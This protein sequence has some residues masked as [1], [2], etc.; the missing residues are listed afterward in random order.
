MKK[1]ILLLVGIIGSIAFQ[2]YSGFEEQVVKNF[3]SFVQRPHEKVY[4]HTDKSAY[5]VGE[6]VWFR[7]YGV[8]ALVHVPEI[9]SRF[10]YVDLVDKRDSL[11]ERVKVGMRDSCFYGQ[12]PLPENLPQGEYCLRAYTYNLQNQGDEYLFKKKI[13]V[14]NPMDSKV[15]TDVSYRKTKDG[16]VAMIKF[17]DGNAEPYAR[18]PVLYSIGAR[19]LGD[20]GKK[21]YTNEKGELEIKIDSANQVVNLSFVDGK[22]FSFNR[23]I[24]VPELQDDFDVQFFPE[25]GS[26]LVGN[27]QQV[28]FKAIGS[29]GHPVKVVGTVYQDSI[30]L[31]EMSSEH[32][33]MGSFKL[34]V[35]WGKKF[36]ALVKTT[37]GMEKW[38]DLPNSRVDGWGIS[39]AK[40]GESMIDYLVMQ[41][42][43]TTPSEPLYVLV[44]SR[45]IV[46]D[47]RP[48]TGKTKG[49]IDKKLLPEGIVQVVLMDGEGKVYSQ[50]L[51]FVKHDDIYPELS[52][53]ADKRQYVAREP[54]EL[55][56]GFEGG[57]QEGVFSLSVTDDQKVYADSLADNILSNLLL[58]SDLRGYIEDP[59]YYFNESTAEVDRHLDLVMQ[60]HGWTRF[61]PGKITRGEFPSAKYEIEVAQMVSGQVKNFWG[62]RSAGANIILLSN[63][64]K[65]YMVETDENGYFTVDNLLF[66]DST[67][68]MVQAMSAKGNQRVEVAI[69]EDHLISPAYNLPNT[70]VEKK[71]DEEFLGK[72]GL[73][74]YYENGEKIYVLDEVNVTRRKKNKVYSFYDNLAERQLDSAKLAMYA[75]R[76]DIFQV[77][78]AEVPGL[79]FTKDT[80]GDVAMMDGRP[81]RVMVNDV[82]ENM[83]LVKSIPVKMLLN[84]SVIER[85]RARV[86]LGDPGAGGILSITAK[87]GYWKSDSRDRL[88]LVSFKLLGY[89]E[90]Q[91]FYV[92][93]Y[94]VDSVR[95]D[96]RYDER[97]TIYWKPRGEGATRKESQGVILH[98]RYLRYL[99]C[100]SGRGYPGWSRV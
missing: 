84:I 32:D 4:L 61:D 48:V 15:Q 33:G 62:K 22:P 42:E 2:E 6:N 44:H 89:Q 51:F 68:F 64:G 21:V 5:V 76:Y 95:Q 43:E 17:L 41:G 39:V 86:L 9:L 16:Y 77:L 24:R 100:H 20:P 96:S 8:H 99:F 47:I 69:R 90:P 65:Y 85:E 36:R 63:Y 40:E 19:K 57:E 55:E 7:A 26:L 70:I 25:G 93:R 29:E 52:V 87:P 72:F 60:T 78:L 49:R 54:V 98:G 37:D 94:D 28:A 71:K 10:I 67:R 73:N 82:E 11:V 30:P 3:N 34:P 31:F 12:V 80:T 1:A 14:V 92:P 58:T 81:M 46:F 91:E 83:M 50:R 27:L 74:Y 38:F 59:A 13:R 88:N 79:S 66:N 97:T 45:G 75:D 18:I 53:K 56:I 35:N 23:Y